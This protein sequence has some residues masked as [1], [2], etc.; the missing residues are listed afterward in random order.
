MTHPLPYALAAA[1]RGWHVFPL[2]HGT[3]VPPRGFTCWEAKATTDPGQIRAWW[4]REPFNIGI[5]TGPSNLVV[6]DLDTPKDPTDTH[7]GADTLIT[8]A[9]GQA[10]PDTFTV[11]T[12]RG[13]THLYYTVPGGTRLAN[14]T[15]TLGHLIDT[16]AHGGYVVGPGSLVA[17]GPY[18]V[19]NPAHAVPLPDWLAERLAPAPLPPQQRVTITLGTDRRAIYLHAAIAG[20]V[21]RITRSPEHGHNNALYQAAVALGQ[22]VAGR[23]L[24][25]PEV[26]SLLLNAARAVGQP[27][28]EANRTIASGLRAGAR[29]PRTLSSGTAA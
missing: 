4:G 23:E 22:L 10:I 15:G 9:N 5:A 12:G 13:G 8:L 25:E 6:I 26:T 1:A 2:A 21:E 29:R 19:T 14:T 24:P 28:G 20:E 7:T 11:R 16:R 3:K 27:Y 18:A 17:T